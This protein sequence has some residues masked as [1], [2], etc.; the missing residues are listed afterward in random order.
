MYSQK[1]Q[2]IVMC[3]NLDYS[4]R[5]SLVNLLRKIPHEINKIHQNDRE[6]MISVN[7]K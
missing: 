5:N 2:N 3:M 1:S 4:V 7:I 6:I